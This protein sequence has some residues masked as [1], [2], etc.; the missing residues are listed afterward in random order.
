MIRQVAAVVA[1][2]A[3]TVCGCATKQQERIAM[4]EE[5][6]RTLTGRL[7]LTRGELDSAVRDRDELNRRLQAAL[8]EVDLLGNQLA[9][10][11]EPQETA[12][13]WTAVPGGAMIAIEGRVLF[14]PGKITLRNAARST[15]DAVRSTLEGT[16]AD[17]DVLVFGHTDNQPIK[18]SGWADNYQL[19]TE[20]ALAVVRYLSGQGVSAKRLV[21]CGC[22]EHRPRVANTSQANRAMNRRVEIYALD[23]QAY[24]LQP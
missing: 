12:P 14:D 8:S 2:V 18:K 20:R 3:T 21:A 6:N 10:R 1:V 19:S 24:G 15:L 7:N 4:L 11:P 23:P 22:G 9:A 16:Y 17:K 13:G 5:A